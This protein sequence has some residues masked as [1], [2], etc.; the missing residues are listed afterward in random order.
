MKKSPIDLIFVIVPIL[1]GI[2][3]VAIPVSGFYR[4]TTLQK[5]INQECNAN[6]SLMEVA[7][8]GDNLIQLCKVKNQTLTLK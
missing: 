8:N 4:A 3:F 5:T 6:Y 2:T 1:I 7:L